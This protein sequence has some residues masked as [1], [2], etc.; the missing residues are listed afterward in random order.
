MICSDPVLKPS[1]VTWSKLLLHGEAVGKMKL[2]RSS[3]T[4]DA[5]IPEI[6]RPALILS[7]AVGRGM[8]SIGEA[9]LE[10]FGPQDDVRHAAIESF[11]PRRAIREDVSRYRFISTHLP[12]A[13]N[14]VYRV[15]FFYYRKLL[16][17]RLRK[18]VEMDGLRDEITEQ[19]IKTVICVSHRAA[20]WVSNLKLKTG[21]D[22]QLWDVLGEYGNNWGY[23]YLFWDALNAFLSPVDR[24]VLRYQIPEHVEWI[25]IDLPA[26]LEYY[27]ISRI[28]GNRNKVLVVAGYWGQASLGGLVRRLLYTSG[29]LRIAV[30]CGANSRLYRGLR[31]RIRD[32]RVEICGAVESLAPFLRE[33]SCVISKPGVS[34]I[35]EARAAGRKLFLLRG[36]PVAEDNN[37][38][39]AIRSFDAEWFS[40]RAFDAWRRASGR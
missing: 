36:M 31:S 10:R 32:E 7:T 5:L 1:V 25:P 26:K 8:Y 37:A 39:F 2:P 4:V 23:K 33:C 18:R 3:C 27:E 11:L 15:P 14:L 12:I 16:R 35:L 19:R 13:L 24:S 20:F 38:R 21:L 17:E 29:D 6:E 22:F 28:P 40:P 34:T 9:I 30:V